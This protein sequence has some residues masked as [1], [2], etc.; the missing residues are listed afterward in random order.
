MSKR[1]KRE[2][3]QSLARKH[4]ELFGNKPRRA[5][6]SDTESLEQPYAGEFVDSVATTSVYGDPKA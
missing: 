6:E 2:T 4:E 5:S 1:A 3:K